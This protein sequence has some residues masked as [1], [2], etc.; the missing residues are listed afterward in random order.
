M[1]SKLRAKSERRVHYVDGTSLPSGKSEEVEEDPKLARFE[2]GKY[3]VVRGR[4]KSRMRL[5][6][7]HLYPDAELLSPTN[8]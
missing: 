8:F 5:P 6:R 4:H 7:K 3:R 2:G 1:Q